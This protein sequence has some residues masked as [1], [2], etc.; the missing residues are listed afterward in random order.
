MR[1]RPPGAA[2]TPAC[3]PPLE[4]RSSSFRSTTSKAAV[5]GEAPRRSAGP[6]SRREHPEGWTPAAGGGATGSTSSS[7]APEPL[8]PLR[9]GLQYRRGQHPPPRSRAPAVL[10]HEVFHVVGRHSAEQMAKTGLTPGTSR[11]VV[12]KGP[13]PLCQ[14]GIQGRTTEVFAVEVAW[15]PGLLGSPAGE[16]EERFTAVSRM[17]KT[18]KSSPKSRDLRRVGQ[19]RGSSV[20]RSPTPSAWPMRTIFPRM[21][22]ST[23]GSHGR[24]KRRTRQG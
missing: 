18:K 3:V 1:R 24:S 6:G 10:G 11:A 14:G 23:M 13:A 9:R 22:P 21:S 5:P 8:R 7:L 2:M 16:L 20:S 4:P 19:T 17:L 12:V 15:E